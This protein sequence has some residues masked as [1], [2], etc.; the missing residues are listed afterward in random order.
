MRVR[1]VKITFAPEGM[2]WW[3]PADQ[4]TLRGEP[5]WYF[6]RDGGG[7]Y[8]PYDSYDLAVE[9]SVRGDDKPVDW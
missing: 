4:L 8:G 5:G 1:A 9:G 2:V 3:S 7:P 6:T